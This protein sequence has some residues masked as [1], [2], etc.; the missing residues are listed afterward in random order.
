MKSRA[1]NDFILLGQW[2]NI[3][4]DDDI[5]MVIFVAGRRGFNSRLPTGLCASHTRPMYRAADDCVSVSGT[6]GYLCCG[7]TAVIAIT[8]VPT[9]GAKQGGW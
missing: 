3:V 1:E 5:Q 7:S 2:S 9:R 8:A 4:T 6:A